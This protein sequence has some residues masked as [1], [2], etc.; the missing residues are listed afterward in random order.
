M[1]FLLIKKIF[2]SSN[3]L[4]G[5]KPY[6][7]TLTQFL[8]INYVFVPNAGAQEVQRAIQIGCA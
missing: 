5:L 1:S 2:S 7:T 4:G 3:V 6:L 8:Q